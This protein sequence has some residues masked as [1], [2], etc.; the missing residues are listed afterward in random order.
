MPKK[1]TTA[2]AELILKLYEARRETELRK[3]R[4]WWVGSF[5]PNTVDDVLQVTRSTGQENA[6]YRM[7]LGY[8]NMAASFVLHG[9]LNEDL[10]MEP[11]F[12][13]EMYFIYAKLKPILK[14]I[15]EKMQNPMFLANVEKLVTR[16]KT[17]RER[18]AMIQKNVEARRKAVAEAAAA[19]A[20]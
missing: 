6:W 1:P 13:G 9:A 12:S 2:D 11:A 20:S 5:W 19:K 4:Q 7:V 10:F 17:G 3:A 14:D 8:W 18:L 16:S 15:R